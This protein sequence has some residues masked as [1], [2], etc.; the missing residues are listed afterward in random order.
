MLWHLSLS[1]NADI[2]VRAQ[3]LHTGCAFYLMAFVQI[4]FSLHKYVELNVCILHCYAC[5]EVAYLAL[6]LASDESSFVTGS[7]YSIDGGVNCVM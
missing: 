6:Y 7:A 3:Y 4:R 2:T 1:S 5:S